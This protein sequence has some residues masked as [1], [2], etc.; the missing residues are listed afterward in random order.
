LKIIEIAHL[1]GYSN[2]GYFSTVFKKRFG[3]KP[4]D[5]R[6][7]MTADKGGAR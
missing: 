3:Q 7:S 5:Y 2:S 4:L 1:V 6:K